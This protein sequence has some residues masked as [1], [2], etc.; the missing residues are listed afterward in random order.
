MTP[1][2][3]SIS[4]ETYEKNFKALLKEF[5]NLEENFPKNK[6]MF[7]VLAEK[8]RNTPLTYRQTDAITRRCQNFINGDF[9]PRAK[10]K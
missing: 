9:Y 7:S 5:E 3:K 4:D 1:K 10:E 2:A 8:A 6:D